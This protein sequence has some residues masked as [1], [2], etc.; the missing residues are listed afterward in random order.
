MLKLVLA[1]RGYDANNLALVHL[2]CGLIA[3]QQARRR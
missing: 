1:L 2:A 3:F